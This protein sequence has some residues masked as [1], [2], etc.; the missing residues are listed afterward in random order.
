MNRLNVDSFSNNNNPKYD[1]Y[2]IN[3]I[4]FVITKLAI[5]FPHNSVLWKIIAIINL[6]EGDENYIPGES[7]TSM[8]FLCSN[9]W[10]Y[11]VNVTNIFLKYLTVQF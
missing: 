10:V 4:I 9:T 8:A 2:Q 6:Q 7:V 11:Y 3:I 1:L 5:F